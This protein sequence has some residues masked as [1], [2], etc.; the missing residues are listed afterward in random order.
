MNHK[1]D[2]PCAAMCCVDYHSSYQMRI[3]AI[4]KSL[5]LFSTCHIRTK[6]LSLLH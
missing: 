6:T 1:F 2:L 4:R 5:A 3:K